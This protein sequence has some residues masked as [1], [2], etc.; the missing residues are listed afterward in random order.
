MKMKE[1]GLPGC[2]S[3]A[4]PLDPPMYK[5]QCNHW[6]LMSVVLLFWIFVFN[7][8]AD[9]GFHQ[10]GGA[11]SPGGWRQHTILPNFPKNCMKL[12]E[13]GPQ[14]ARVPCAP[15]LDPP[16]QLVVFDSGGATDHSHGHDSLIN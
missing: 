1:F 11:N 14:G 7:S 2:A 16:L 9:P 5:I 12:K 3:L 15:P 8:V 4:P 10:G 13:F 6:R